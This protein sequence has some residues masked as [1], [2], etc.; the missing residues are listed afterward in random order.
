MIGSA[1]RRLAIIMIIMSIGCPAAVGAAAEGRV[2]KLATDADVASLDPH[3]QLSAEALQYSHIVFDP[4]VR[5]AADMTFAPRLALRW[6]RIGDTAMR[7]YLRRDVVFHSGR[8]FTAEDVKWTVERLM[9][10]PDYKDLFAMIEEIKIIDDYTVDLVTRKPYALILNMAAFIFP[11]DRRFYWGADQKGRYKDAIVKAG[12]AFALNNVSGTGKYRVTSR[13]PGVKT[14]FERFPYYW[15]KDATGNVDTIILTPINND[16]TR[17][18]ALFS[19]R[20]DLIMPVPVQEFARIAADENLQLVT[21]A[22]SRVITL[23]LNQ[24]RRKE[25]RD[26]RVRLA[27][28]MAVDTTKIVETIMKGGATAA[29][30]QGPVGFAGYKPDL[31]PRFDLAGARALM[32]EAG[33]E[34]GFTCNMIAPNNRYVND[35]KIAAA[36]ADM[37]SKINITV[38]LKTLPKTHYWERFDAQAADIQM[39]GWHP[40]MEDSANYSE[41]LVMCPDPETGFGRYNSGNYCNAKVDALVLAS[42]MEIDGRRRSAM[43]RQVEQILYDEAAFIPLHWQNLSWAG[44]RNI[45]IGAVV[46]VQNLSYL[47]DLVI[48]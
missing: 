17:V 46:N 42:R 15:D 6:E 7:F 2:L 30:Q 36:A 11:M 22:G 18:K 31:A 10:S 27:M 44:K 19:G 32:K 14:I 40:E 41:F 39:I 16:D 13:N 33:Y 24:K 45:G 35:G 29:G 8:K 25:F 9:R 26:P 43:L 38:N 28:A 23:Q 1:A 47:G 3:V 5:R 48:H 4:L 37:L 21:M 20:V 12:P 34:N